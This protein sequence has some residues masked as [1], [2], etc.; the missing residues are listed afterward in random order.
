M[1]KIFLIILLCFLA[2]VLVQWSP[3]I[4]RY[5]GRKLADCRG[6]LTQMISQDLKIVPL[7][8]SADI[9]A[10]VDSD[11]VDMQGIKSATFLLQF[12]ATLAGASGCIIKLY[13]G[14]THGAKTTA[15]TFNYKYGGAAVKSAT[16]DV[17]SA[18]ATSAALQI[19]TATLASRML[20]IDI[21]AD[22]I[23]DGHRY[24]TLEIG[25]EADA[26]ELSIAALLDP[27]FKDPSGDTVID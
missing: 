6:S 9:N 21:N 17:F 1:E 13:S 7:L 10:G 2:V 27:M 23:T 14:V 19:A 5:I 22:Q 16:A 24:L 20:I 15:M 26:G 12:F 8:V 18:I 25:A 3:S 11:S 4:G